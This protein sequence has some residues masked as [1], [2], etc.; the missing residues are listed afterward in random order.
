MIRM[1][2]TCEKNHSLNGPSWGYIMIL[3]EYGNL[4]KIQ[5][6]SCRNP[7][8]KI[9]RKLPSRQKNMTKRLPG[10]NPVLRFDSQVSGY[11]TEKFLNFIKSFKVH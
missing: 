11:R 9:F 1:A 7:I 10:I 8:N 3:P 6:I 4:T 5:M 2:T